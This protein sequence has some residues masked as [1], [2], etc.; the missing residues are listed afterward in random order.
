ML[1]KVPHFKNNTILLSCICTSTI[2][3]VVRVKEKKKIYL[4]FF[5]L[6]YRDNLTGVQTRTD[7][8][9]GWRENNDRREKKNKHVWLN[10]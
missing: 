10:S 7:S 6:W 3:K 4:F 1:S 8:A 9:V 5:H 2:F